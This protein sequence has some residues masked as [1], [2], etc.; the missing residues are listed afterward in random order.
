MS[1]GLALIVIFILYLIDKHNRWRQAVKILGGF[2][3]AAKGWLTGR[4]HAVAQNTQSVARLALKHLLPVF[5]AKLPCDI[6]PCDIEDYQR[7]RILSAAQGR[8]VNI[9]V[10]TLR[11]ILKAN[12]LWLPFSNKVRMLRERRERRKGPRARAGT[13]SPAG[14]CGCRF[15]VPYRNTT[16]P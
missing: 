7:K 9:E 8:T 11:Q 14:N 4:G 6:A 12:D 13:D 16:C 3:N 15:R 10:A 1:I 2:E 5:G